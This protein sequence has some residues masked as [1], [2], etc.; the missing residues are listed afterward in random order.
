MS[1]GSPATMR[2]M[3]LRHPHSPLQLTCMLLPAVLPGTLRLKVEACGVCRTD[4]HL[5]DGELPD[6]VLPMIPGPEIDRKS[7]RLNSSHQI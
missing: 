3:V 5:V 6:P 2:A 1:S 4:L 7:T